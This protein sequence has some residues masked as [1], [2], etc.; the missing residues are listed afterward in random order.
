MLKISTQQSEAF[1]YYEATV[2]QGIESM[3]AVPSYICHL[4]FLTSPHAH[5]Y[6][7]YPNKEDGRSH[8]QMVHLAASE[9]T[10][11]C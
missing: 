3:T 6:T 8:Y 4:S 1:R 10:G 2:L 9:C 7:F 5:H 11:I